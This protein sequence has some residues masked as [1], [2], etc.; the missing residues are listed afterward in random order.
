MVHQPVFLLLLLLSL[1]QPLQI[2]QSLPVSAPDR[3]EL[4]AVRFQLFPLLPAGLA[5][6]RKGLQGPGRGALLSR[7]LFFQ[8]GGP[9]P[10]AQ[11]L[12]V[13]GGPGTLPFLHVLDR[14]AGLQTGFF[15]VKALLLPAVS[16]GEGRRFQNLLKPFRIFFR[17]LQRARLLLFLLKQGVFALFCLRK[18]FLQPFLFLCQTGKRAPRL[19]LGLAGKAFSDL[20]QRA[21]RR[22]KLLPHF[23]QQAVR[24]LLLRF[25]L[26]PVLFRPGLLLL[27]LFQKLSGLLRLL[28]TLLHLADAFHAGGVG[29]P[30]PGCNPFAKGFL[31]A[32][33]P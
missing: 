8:L 3:R 19:F 24:F 11:Q 27:L 32:V 6:V 4:S 31:P 28:Q 17:R 14:G 20:L 16:P 33:F 25:R 18:S 10:A 30:A 9:L 2:F 21:L 7:K 26:F 22:G 29:A 1:P 5:A 15:A 12:L 13:V 23:Q